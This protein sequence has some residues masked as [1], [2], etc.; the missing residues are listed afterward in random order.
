MAVQRRE[1]PLTVK[2][3]KFIDAYTTPPTEGNGV[4]SARA[5]GYTGSY[6]ALG[7]MATNLLKNPKIRIP[8]NARLAEGAKD[9]IRDRNYRLKGYADRHA[10]FMSIVRDRANSPQFSVEPGASSGF[11]TRKIKRTRWYDPKTGELKNETEET[12]Y[13]FDAGLARAVLDLEKQAA[14]E[15][16]EFAEKREVYGANGQPLAIFEVQVN[17]QVRPPDD[18]DVIEAESR[19]VEMGEGPIVPTPRV[20]SERDEPDPV[21]NDTMFTGWGRAGILSDD[22]D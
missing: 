7:A 18:L 9:G 17:K 20:V 3:S 14:I 4:E 6:G 10:V 21:E 16:G 11:M 8:I 15:L 19:F 12:E 22:D 1:R 13:R 2:Q 5:A